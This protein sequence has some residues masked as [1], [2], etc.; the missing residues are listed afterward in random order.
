MENT[1]KE[2]FRGKWELLKSGWRGLLAG[3]T[4]CFRDKIEKDPKAS[5]AWKELS[6]NLKGLK[7]KDTV[8]GFIVPFFLLAIGM[9]SPC[10]TDS[11]KA[12][13]CAF[14]IF[15]GWCG[16]V[17]LFVSMEA[18]RG[19]LVLYVIDCLLSLVL[20]SICFWMTFIVN[21]VVAACFV[22]YSVISIWS[23]SNYALPF[24]YGGDGGGGN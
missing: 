23:D 7:K 4:K 12:I 22:I 16:F 5:K 24:F 21:F 3:Q 14:A 15:Y 13:F 1:R 2:N 9:V 18:R 8:L 19:I 17:S 11:F 20:T 10:F 6:G